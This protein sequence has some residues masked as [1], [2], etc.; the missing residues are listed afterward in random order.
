MTLSISSTATTTTTNNNNN[1]DHRHEHVWC[2]EPTDDF[3]TD[4][5]SPTN[6]GCGCGGFFGGGCGGGSSSSSG[7]GGVLTRAGITQI[8]T[9][10]KYSPGTYTILDNVLNPTWTWITYNLLP[11]WIAPNTVTAIGGLC[12]LFSYLVTARYYY[13][14]SPSTAS[15]SA[16]FG[17]TAVTAAFNSDTDSNPSDDVKAMTT[18]MMMNLPNWIYI[19]NGACLILYYTLDC[20][21]G[22]LCLFTASELSFPVVYCL[23]LRME[24]FDTNPGLY[25][26]RQ[27]SLPHRTFSVFGAFVVCLCS[28]QVNKHVV[29]KVQVH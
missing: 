24:G 28:L 29:R 25:L 6:D 7:Y 11:I 12:C 27:Q 23:L 9:K 13:E 5:D 14:L 26:S 2:F 4:T 16:T 18:T 21:D 20:C 3:D 22:T 10:W 8:T 15:A 19:M 1:L 17:T